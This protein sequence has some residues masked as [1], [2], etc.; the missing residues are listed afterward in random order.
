MRILFLDA[1]FEPEQ[2][3]FTHLEN[4]LLEGLVEAGY[5]VEVVCPTPT[6]G[7]SVEVAKEYKNRK[8]ETLH[9]GHVH[10]TRFSAPKEGKNALIR[11]LRYFWC[12]LCT[13]QIGKRVKNIDIVFSN[14][15]PPTQGWIAGK[16]ARKHKVPFIYSLQDIF[17]DSLV[18]AEMTK[19]G[20]LIWK[21]GRMIENE[22]YKN[23][24]RIIA[25][26]EEFKDNLMKKS[27]EANKVVIIPNWIDTSEVYDVPR[28][29]NRIIKKY[30]LDPKKFYICYSGNIGYSQNM[31]L[32]VGVA[33]EISEVN[34]R[35]EFV[36]IGEGVAKENLKKMIEN[37][38][39]S[40]VHLLPFQPYEDIAHVFSLGDVGLIISKPG[41]GRSS[42][43]SKAWGIMAANRPII[44]SFDEGELT[45]IIREVKCGYVSNANNQ[46]DLV[47]II[48]KSYNDRVCLNKLSENGRR[49]VTTIVNKNNCVESYL[50]SIIE[51]VNQNY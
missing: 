38:Q 46:K 10:V 42:V 27:V 3:A 35:I 32:L 4:D 15:T 33:R 17:P 13:Y 34:N 9:N 1:Y 29:E 24:T 41:I 8:S 25:I 44:A 51:V 39:V 49:Y 19:E 31:E 47:G 28:L 22:T 23:A 43:P 40:N 30:G 12:N 21:V 26:S 5:E 7:V 18:N 14:S 48:E 37:N 16:V 36:I 45:R 20:S 2:V 6:R 11:T 50:K